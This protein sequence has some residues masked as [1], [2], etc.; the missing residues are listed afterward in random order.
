VPVSRPGP[1][2]SVRSVLA[3][4]A[5][6]ALFQPIVDLDSQA[7]IGYEA[8]ARGPVGSPLENPLDLFA[9]ARADGLLA[10]LDSACRRQAFRSAVDSG[11]LAPLT[12]FVNVEPEVLDDAPLDDLLQIA[13]SAP[14]ALR[15]VFEITERAISARPAELLRTVARIRDHGWAI[16]LDDVGADPRSLAFMSLLQPE[17]VKLDLRLIQQRPSPEIAGIVHAVNAYAESSGAMLLAEGIETTE[18]VAS[19]RALGARFGQGWLFGRPSEQ[20]SSLRIAAAELTRSHVEPAPNRSP[21]DCL[22]AGTS[23]RRAGKTLLIALSKQLEQEAL[24]RGD[25]AIVAS[26]FQEARHFTIPTARR[27]QRLVDE[28]AFVCVFGE[29]LASPPLAG[30]R[31]AALGTTDPLVGEW[32]VVVLTPHFAAA[33]LARDLG[34]TGPDLERTFEYALTYRRDVVVR[35]ASALMSRVAPVAVS[36][37][38]SPVQCERQARAS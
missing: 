15:V 19:A 5:L 7:V 38:A 32:D 4:G 24:E 6:R 20:P 13:T 30:I 28:T 10:E 23:L 27:Y 14:R 9:A 21:F 36:R 22:A 17:V 3:S 11:R 2:H 26:A 8:L 31:G 29:G 16:A 35:A 34:D 25:T 12:L 37:H 18:H 1:I 33:L